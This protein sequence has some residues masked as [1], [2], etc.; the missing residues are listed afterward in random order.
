MKPQLLSRRYVSQPR[1]FSVRRAS[2]ST[3]AASSAGTCHVEEVSPIQAEMCGRRPSVFPLQRGPEIRGGSSELSVTRQPA[4]R[5]FLKRVRG[6]AVE[7]FQLDVGDRS[8]SPAPRPHRRYGP[9]DPNSRSPA[10]HGPMRVGRKMVE[11]GGD[12][13]PACQFAGMDRDA[14]ARFPGHVESAGEIGGVPGALV[15]GHPEA[16]DQRMSAFRQ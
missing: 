10:R 9:P 13:L 2:S 6:K 14:E 3:K 15:P 5:S 8:R 4:S 16:G 12:A 11:R 1:V 7:D